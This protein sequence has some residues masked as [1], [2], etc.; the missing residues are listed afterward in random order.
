VSVRVS[1]TLSLDDMIAANML[2]QRRY[3]IWS[4]LLKIFAFGTP[5]YFLLMLAVMTFT[6]PTL[7]RAVIEWLLQASL[8]VGLGMVVFIPLISLLA[9]R[10]AVKR[11][12]E[13][14][15]V[16]LP[17]EY[18]IDANGVRASNEQGTATLTWDRFSDFV[19]DSRL[20]LLRRTRRVFFVLPKGQLGSDELE[21]ILACLRQAGVEEG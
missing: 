11:Q 8:C 18:E 7:D 20:L 6:G 1:V 14:L 17:I 2:Y 21:T 15:C 13:Q 10:L 9:M 12:F 19:Q 16:G 5:S 4:G 3:W